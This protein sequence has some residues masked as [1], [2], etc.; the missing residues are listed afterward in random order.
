MKRLYNQH[1]HYKNCFVTCMANIRL[2]CEKSLAKSWL[3]KNIYLRGCLHC[4]CTVGATC[5]PGHYSVLATNVKLP[6]PWSC[7]LP[8]HH[9]HVQCRTRDHCW[10]CSCMQWCREPVHIPC[11][12]RRK[13]ECRWLW[14]WKLLY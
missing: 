10:S 5:P 12:E 6:F 4:D 8:T 11:S 7:P 9:H 13:L 14:R 2:T 1:D 3:K